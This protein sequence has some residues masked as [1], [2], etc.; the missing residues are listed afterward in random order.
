MAQKFY[1]VIRAIISSVYPAIVR[2]AEQARFPAEFPFIPRIY[3]RSASNL[4]LWLSLSLSP[5]L[6]LFRLICAAPVRVRRNHRRRFVDF[7]KGW[8]T[9]GYVENV[10]GVVTGTEPD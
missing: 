6:P 4:I 10:S 1:R 8:R 2:P 7:S 5:S 9:D 3:A